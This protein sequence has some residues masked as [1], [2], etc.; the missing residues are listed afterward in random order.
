MVRNLFR[1]LRLRLLP[2]IF[3]LVLLGALHNQIYGQSTCVSG[4]T[5]TLAT[6]G[7]TATGQPN[8]LALATWTFS[9]GATS[10]YNAC[11][12]IIPAGLTLTINSNELWFG[13]VIVSGNIIFNQRLSLG[14]DPLQ[15]NC[16]FTLTITAS[17][18]INEDASN[19]ANE[20]LIICGVTLI[21][22]Q[23]NPPPG[24]VDWP[25][26]GFNGPTYFPNPAPVSLISFDV[27]ATQDSK[28][29]ATWATAT[30]KDADYFAIERS[31]NGRDFY[32]LGIVSAAGTTNLRQ[33]YAF[34]DH[35]PL[36][37]RAYYR[38]KQV[39]FDGT[40]EYFPVKF[41]DLSGSKRVMVY[42]TLLENNELKVRL[43]F[44][45]EEVAYARIISVSGKEA[46]SFTFTGSEFRAPVGL[47]AGAYL[48]KVNIGTEQFLERFVV[49]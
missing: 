26:G 8:A 40:T 6:T 19:S 42:P 3:T 46:G 49:R 43:N 32:E 11:T 16:N 39:D 25:P 38:L 1:K 18:N 17:G 47:A 33:D 30:E 12:I 5:A 44:T 21:T 48:L 20:R 24:A 4:S 29:V 13:N 22:S 27:R 37:G 34:T 45:S 36:I 15:T 10:I 31:F 28:I 9:G 41:I 35:Y 2:G 14:P 23:P 7:K